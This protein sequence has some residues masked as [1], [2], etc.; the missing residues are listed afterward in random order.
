MKLEKRN[1]RKFRI[2]VF[3]LL[4][5]ILLSIIGVITLLSTT[6]GI[7]GVFEDTEIVNKQIAF[8]IIGF[9]SYLLISLI[10]ISLLKHW[11]VVLPIYI[12]TLLLLLSVFIWGP[13]INGVQRWL[14]VGGIQIQPS[15]IAKITV[16]FTTACVFGFKDRY[17][18][19]LLLLISFLLVLPLIILIYLEPAGSM[20]LLTL[21]IWFLVA[22]TGLSNQLRN[23]VALILLTLFTLPFLL[24]SITGNWIYIILGIVGVILSIFA[25]YFRDTWRLVV[26]LSVVIG[27]VLGLSSLVMYKGVLREYQKD[28]IEAFLNPTENSGDIGFNVNQARIAIGSGQIWGKG[29]GNG[30][31]S[32]RDFLPEHQTDFI[33]ASFAEEF[34]LVGSLFLLFLFSVIIIR[35]LVVSVDNSNDS[36]L[37]MILIGIVMKILLEIFI[38][39][40]TNTGLIPATGIPLPLISAGGTITVMTLF[41]LGVIQSIMNRSQVT[42]NNSNIIDNY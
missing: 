33:Y 26:I 35:G 12:G 24:I 10:D 9:I 20:S 39:V 22:F 25:Y 13:E 1:K 31:Q 4:P 42:K 30:T 29:F 21:T 40:G 37:S 2:D 3:I 14:V 18:Q 5:A 28:R 27:I 19:W 32:K 8:L 38:N 36:F 16:I 23:T 17:N 7:D 34:G 41:A 6:L 11:E 15:E